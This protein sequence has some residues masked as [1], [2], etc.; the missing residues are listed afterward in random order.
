M[1]FVGFDGMAR[2]FARGLMNAHIIEVQHGL[3]IQDIPD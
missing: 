3:T 1:G 2:I